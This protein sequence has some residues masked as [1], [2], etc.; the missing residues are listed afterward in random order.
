MSKGLKIIAQLT[1]WLLHPLL[2]PVIGFVIFFQ[3][4]T[5]LQLIYSPQDRLSLFILIATTTFVVPSL[6]TLLFIV[7]FRYNDLQLPE[8]KNRRLPLLATAIYYSAG[9]YLIKIKIPLPMPLQLYFLGA[10][11]AVVLNMFIN[12]YYKISS[13]AIGVGGLFGGV[14]S[15]MYLFH[16]GQVGP[17]VICTFLM[18]IVATSRLY[19]QAHTPSQVY[20][21]LLLGFLCEFLLFH[22]VP[23]FG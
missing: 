7:I 18:G 2:I 10:L 15:F 3:F 22:M 14:L 8:A 19:L 12:R 1:S 23:N 11:L 17:L 4:P 20:F 13:H 16:I 5:Y 21:G 6:T 9:Y